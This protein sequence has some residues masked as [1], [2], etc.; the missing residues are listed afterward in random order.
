MDVADWARPFEK[1]MLR[2]V[3][4]RSDALPHL[5]KTVLL[6]AGP[7]LDGDIPG[8]V[9]NAC[10]QAL[11][12]EGL[13]ADDATARAMLSTGIVELQPAQDHGV[14]TPLAQ[15]VSAS[16][17]LA[18]VGNDQHMRWAPLVEGPAPA[19]R[20]GTATVQARERLAVMAEFG[21][22]R[23]SGLLRANPV[24]LF[25]IVTHALE[26]GDECHARTGAA[27]DALVER[28][29][30][31]SDDER[32]ML[33]ASPGFALPI[34][35]AAALW[36]LQQGT[37]GMAAC[38]GNGVSFG[39][40][41]H[42]DTRWRTQPSVPPAGTRFAGHADTEALGAIG[43]SAVV[44]VCGLGGQAMSAAPVLCEEWRALLPPSLSAQRAAVIDP[45]TGLVDPA[46]VWSS[47]VSPLVN[48]A[49]L[50]RAG[51]AGL[52]GRGVYSPGAALFGRD[53]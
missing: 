2:D 24:P 40:R 41:L 52:I 9:R 16:M 7:P 44:D 25:P 46:R 34:L 1:A 37:T 38:G 15:V 10:V 51:D 43:D 36:R 4:R 29:V 35:M 48:L 19:L 31:L 22:Q 13:A 17:P 53:D 27:N 23:L 39:F 14:A 42:G 33:Q 8:P 12:F 3:V 6:H 5:A 28:I 26:Q 18:A 30:G 21:L 45:A 47:G 49:V 20:F 50:D 32:R 11:L